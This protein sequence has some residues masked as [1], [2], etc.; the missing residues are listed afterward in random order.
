MCQ[1]LRDPPALFSRAWQS[2]SCG[3]V[4]VTLLPWLLS[5]FLHNRRMLRD[6]T[7]RAS[8]IQDQPRCRDISDG[9][10]GAVPALG[11]MESLLFS[12]TGRNWK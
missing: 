2:V 10:E 1:L 12:D 6:K 8:R 3:F 5:V 7:G 4:N 9:E 11:M